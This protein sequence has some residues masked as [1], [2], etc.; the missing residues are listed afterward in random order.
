MGLGACCASRAF[1]TTKNRIP[2]KH[3]CLY[4]LILN[5]ITWFY[6]GLQNRGFRTNANKVYPICGNLLLNQQISGQLL[7]GEFILI[8]IL[9]DEAISIFEFSIH[10][11]KTRPSAAIFFIWT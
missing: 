8:L 11:L 6:K 9:Q 7:S 3:T 2:D 4:N 5:M 10:F 1:A